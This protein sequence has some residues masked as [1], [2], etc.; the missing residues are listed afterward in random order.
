MFPNRPL[1]PPRGKCTASF[2]RRRWTLMTS[3]SLWRWTRRQKTRAPHLR[4]NRLGKKRKGG[5]SLEP[6]PWGRYGEIFPGRFPFG[7]NL[8]QVSKV[9][10]SRNAGR[11]WPVSELAHKPG[12][13]S[14]ASGVLLRA[15]S[16]VPLV[17][18]PGRPGPESRH[19]SFPVPVFHVHKVI[20]HPQKGLILKRYGDDRGWFW[21]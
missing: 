3:P 1:R 13:Q 9:L 18:D 21:G 11:A 15:R 2:G 7:A 6:C 16:R 19:S 17:Y 10:S 5:A 20:N 8:E 12:N 14:G 4:I